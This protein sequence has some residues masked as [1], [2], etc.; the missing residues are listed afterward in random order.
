MN[1]CRGFT[2]IE[3]MIALLLTALV[4]TLIFGSLRLTSRGWDAADQQQ[5]RI[6]RQ[7]QV[8]QLLRRLIG[9]ARDERIRD[10]DSVLQVAFRGEPDQ[11]VFVA[12]AH[13]ESGSSDLLW[14]RLRVEE[15]DEPDDTALVLDT[16]AFR[17]AEIVDWTLLFDEEPQVGPEE[18][19]PAPRVSHRLL[20]LNEPQL[21]FQYMHVRPGE[22]AEVS[23]SWIQNGELPLRV[24]LMLQSDRAQPRGE[25]LPLW[26]ELSFSLRE[27][28]YA[29]RTVG[30]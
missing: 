23:D 25:L 30:F 10:I 22:L 7:Y 13:A 9:Q 4:M 20:S 2:L 15:S 26:Q 11:L 6:S 29:V 17:S 14:Y 1:R 16:R 5:E 19:A 3:M 12:P 18:S 27:Y 24:D 21:R 28:T 8:Q